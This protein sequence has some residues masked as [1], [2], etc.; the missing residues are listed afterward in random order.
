MGQISYGLVLEA[1]EAMKAEDEANAYLDAAY[2]PSPARWPV[3]KTFVQHL[4]AA[5]NR[6]PLG[7]DG[8][9]NLRKLRKRKTR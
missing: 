6:E 5:V 8:R 9:P 7:R 3:S 4:E 2:G 1:Y